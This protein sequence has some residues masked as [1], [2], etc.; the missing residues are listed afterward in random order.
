MQR[1][2]TLLFFCTTALTWSGCS[3]KEDDDPQFD[4]QDLLGKWEA[5]QEYLGDTGETVP[6]E[7]YRDLLE[8]GPNSMVVTVHSFEDGDIPQVITLH[9]TY[10]IEGDMLLGEDE[11]GET[12]S[13]RI[14]VLTPTEFVYSYES[15]NS[16]QGTFRNK[17]YYRR[18]G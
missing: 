1:I 6:Y 10:T 8:I 7:Q 14:E 5:Y 18:I 2:F 15:S 13:F 11:E 17:T 4:P 12:Y 9:L 3:E 16:E